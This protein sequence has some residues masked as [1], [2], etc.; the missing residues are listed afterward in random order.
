MAMSTKEKILFLWIL[1]VVAFG[2]VF[3]HF[4]VTTVYVLGRAV[5]LTLI[6]LFGLAK[7]AAGMYGVHL[8]L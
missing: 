1:A 5:A 4:W 6:S 7:V 2:I 8:L 3:H